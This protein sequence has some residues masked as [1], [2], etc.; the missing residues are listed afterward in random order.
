MKD[1]MTVE[2][3]KRVNKKVDRWVIIFCTVFLLCLIG[4][5]TWRYV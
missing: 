1:D 3:M 4:D 2:E 5:I